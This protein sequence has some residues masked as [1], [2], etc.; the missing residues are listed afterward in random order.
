[1][2]FPR[3][4]FRHLRVSL[5]VPD[6][7]SQTETNRRFHKMAGKTVARGHN[8]ES[9]AGQVVSAIREQE[10]WILT[11]PKWIEVLRQRIDDMEDECH[12]VTGFGG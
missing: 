6:A 2:R 9:V 5:W 8:P 10:F 1:V 3:R 4:R 11:H 12:L 7:A